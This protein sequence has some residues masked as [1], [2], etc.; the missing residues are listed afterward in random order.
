M[1][2]F[3]LIGWAVDPAASSQK[4]ILFLVSDDMRP[5]IGAYLGP[6]FPSPVHPKPITPALDRLA[7]KSL[8]LKNAHCQQAICSPSRTSL[9]TGRRPDT[10]HVYDLKT[11]FRKVG[12]NFTTIP[13]FFKEHGYLSI[14]MGKIFHPG[15]KASGKDDPIS[16]SE[17]YF[18]GNHVWRNKERSW[19]AVTPDDIKYVNKRLLMIN[20][21]SGFC[22]GSNKLVK[23]VRHAKE[24]FETLKI[25]LYVR[26]YRK[27]DYHQILVIQYHVNNKCTSVCSAVF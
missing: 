1:L 5:Q 14:G 13:Q 21:Q 2:S 9:L 10:T 25:E 17:P 7:S 19:W 3:V 27:T 18:H 26:D 12:G 23:P 22:L 15:E 20:L 8:V 11:Y 24:Q 4:N 16:W 6:D